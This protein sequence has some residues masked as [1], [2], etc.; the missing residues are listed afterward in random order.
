VRHGQNQLLL[1][2]ILQAARRVRVCAS[3]GGYMIK[4]FSSLLT[5]LC[6]LVAAGAA[7][8]PQ[9]EQEL[10]TVVVSATRSSQSTLTIPGS[11]SIIS[12]DEIAASGANTLGEVLRGQGGVQIRDLYGDGSRT[13]ISLRGF[14]ANAGANTLVLV[15]GRRLNNP[16]L[17]P[18]DLNTI[19]LDDVERIEI[20]QGSAGTLFGDQAVGGV[21]N[22][23][24]RTPRG[25]TARAAAGI[26]AYD[27]RKLGFSIA[28]RL[29]NGL[30]FRLSVDDRTA[31]NYRDN[32]ERDYRNL[33]ARASYDHSRGNVFLELGRLDEDINLPG[34][35]FRADFRQDRRQ[36]YYPRDFA[37][38]VTDSGRL[39]IQHSL[40]E[41]WSLEGELTR[42]ATDVNGVLTGF[43]FSQQREVN[44]FT[45]RF[46][47]SYA[48][49]HGEMLFTLGADIINSDYE[50]TSPFGVTENDQ[51][52]QSVYAQAVIPVSRR[53]TL[54]AGA[55]SAHVENDLYDSWAFP[56]GIDLDDSETVWELGL[57]FQMSPEWRLYGRFDRNFRFAKVDEQTGTL[58]GVV[59]LDTQ[60]GKSWETGAEWKRG[61]NRFKTV[62]YRLRLDN[63]IDYDTT[64]YANVNL[65][66]TLRDGM[67]IEAHMVPNDRLA[68]S[69][70]YSYVD[71]RFDGGPLSGNRIPFVA[72]H[73]MHLG[74]NYRFNNRWSLFG[75]MQYIHDRVAAAD[76]TNSL[77]QLNGHTVFNMNLNY[78][79]RNWRASLRI[80]NLTGRKYSDYAASAYNPAT[81]SNETGFYAAPEHNLMMTVQYAVN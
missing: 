30:A 14:G 40:T 70:Q 6:G 19:S 69:G 52:M 48:N 60:T 63:E 11:I 35:L 43:N 31:D 20:I 74:A 66:P 73:V 33:L 50:I 44:E 13:V 21:I 1:F 62:L 34:G 53:L 22:I 57:S 7:A 2:I 36:T 75:E 77:E 55:R 59:G 8:G 47:G 37:D 23:I 54:T 49:R 24:T 56:G 9:Q 4:P 39:G 80:N 25:F 51:G 3:N 29:A 12:R 38:T 46:I 27:T 58:G 26:A 68:L 65:D 67:I 16:D 5:L 41:H 76:I 71:A 32:N 78:H 72:E 42:R 64:V 28:N 45:P 10:Q 15:D 81:F 61:G 17:A 79:Y 18:P